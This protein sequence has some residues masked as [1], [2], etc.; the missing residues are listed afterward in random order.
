MATTSPI[1][2]P[3]APYGQHGTHNAAGT[4]C[5]A[6][7]VAGKPDS[8]RCLPFFY[9][10][11][12]FCTVCG[13]LFQLLAVTL[14]HKNKNERICVMKK[15][16]ITSL[17][18]LLTVCPQPLRAETL[19]TGSGSWK[20]A[21]D[22]DTRLFSLTK[23]DATLLA[24]AYIAVKS[25]TTLL[26]GSYYA[27]CSLSEGDSVSAD[28]TR[29]HTACFRYEGQGMATAEQSFSFPEGKDW[30]L[31]EV[32]LVGTD[33]APVSTNYLAPLCSDAANAFLPSSSD[34]RLLFVPFDNDGFVTYG[35]L[36]LSQ[37]KSAS[38]IA[39]SGPLARDTISF[40]VTAIFNGASQQG[41]VVGSTTHDTWKSAVRMKGNRDNRT[42][43]HLELFSGVSHSATRDELPHGTVKGARVSSAR[44]FV[45][46]FDD[47]R[48]G[49]E[50]FADR[51]AAEVPGMT[52]DGGTP[53][54]WNSW[55]GMSTHVNYEGVL[56]ASD[57]VHNHL[58]GH[59]GWGKDG[60][61]FVGLDSYWDN[62]NWEQLRD[63][64]DR[65]YANG[66]VPGIYWTPFNDWFPDND[67]DMEG[68]NG[69]RYKQGQLKV[70]GSVKRLYGAGCLD[71]THPATLSRI[72]FYMGKFRQ[73]GFRYV[74]LDFLPA[75]MVEADSWYNKDI[76]TGTQAFNY[77]MSYLRKCA[78]DDMFIVES[79]APLFPYQ[80]AQARRVSCDAWGEMWH[81]NYMMNSLSFGWWLSRLYAYNDPD[82]LVM[83]DRSDGE[84]KTRVT[85]G[86]VTGYCMVGDNLSTEGNYVGTPSSQ[87]RV[88][89]YFVNE[90]VNAVISLGRSFR[91]AYGHKTF[92]DNRAVD[93]FTLDTDEAWYIAYFNYDDY[94]KDGHLSLA[95]LGIDPEQVEEVMECWSGD[96][97]TL[98][99]G[100]ITYRLP[101]HTPQLFK[102]KKAKEN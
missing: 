10:C 82:H 13:D 60:V 79:I 94:Q 55:G 66:Q 67:R 80:Y 2:Y 12:I 29:W 61:V 36:P 89:K 3:S 38:A 8:R 6:P 1:P 18:L 51:N 32:A 33:A 53:Y 15:S 65:C 30:F 31:T 68:N 88:K 20:V 41:L 75:G 77:G 83:G 71:P 69:Y 52:W 76:T 21:L 100:S 48:D 40:E 96:Y 11:A 37:S 44:M 43:A 98:F 49:M 24:D 73:L 70:H 95:S 90:R 92:G 26:K 87:E 78:G 58:Q 28:G 45:G 7:A 14:P 62:L 46:Y 4:P 17:V 81:S 22:T 93:L 97:V 34:N 57:F 64:A 91:P 63:F 56:S 19:T 84:N 54:G 42:L 50:T 85:T 59:G 74:K 35:S 16:L 25:G 27:G 47:W 39:S 101:A 86:A 5:A 102:V 23:G 72:A 99:D 9:I